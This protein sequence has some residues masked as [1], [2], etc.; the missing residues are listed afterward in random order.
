MLIPDVNVLVY[1]LRE[2]S[3][4]HQR[5]RDWLQSLVDGEE[6]FGLSELACS[7]FVRLVTNPRIWNPPTPISVALEFIDSLRGRRNCVIVS[8]GQRH[9]AIF[10]DLCR[11]FS[12]QGNVVADTYFAAMA[13]ESGNEWVTVDRGFRQFPGLRWRQPLRRPGV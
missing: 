2:E 5:Y 1:A 13:I 11:Q 3:L 7:G 8:P 4:D 9:W 12:L 10:S 6:S